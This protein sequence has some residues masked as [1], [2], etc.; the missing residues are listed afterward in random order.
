MTQYDKNWKCGMRN[1]SRKLEHIL[2]QV[3]ASC[4]TRIWHSGDRKVR[5]RNLFFNGGVEKTFAGEERDSGALA[6]SATYD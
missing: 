2:A 3:L 5:A 4:Q 6:K 1:C